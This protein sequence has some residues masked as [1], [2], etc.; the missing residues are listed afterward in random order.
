MKKATSSDVVKPARVS[1][2]TVSHVVNHSRVVSEKTLLSVKKAIKELSYTPDP[3]AK[4]FHAGK[5]KTMTR[6]CG[7]SAV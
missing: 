3:L 7:K 5:S 4:S 1:A 2:A 6:Q